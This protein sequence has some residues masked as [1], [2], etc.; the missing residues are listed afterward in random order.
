MRRIIITAVIAAI[1]VTLAVTPALAGKG[2]NGG[3][4]GGGNSTSD[5]ALKAS[6]NPGT[7]GQPVYISGCG[8]AVAPVVLSVVHPNGYV[9]NSNVA[10]WSTGCLAG[11]GFVPTVAGTYTLNI[12]QINHGQTSTVA[13]TSVNVQ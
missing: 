4:G 5:P 1:A 7:V 10:M 3:G 11:G 13:S 12:L 9:Q 6:P 2:G 8:F